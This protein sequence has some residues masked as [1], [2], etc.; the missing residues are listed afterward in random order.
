MLK[1]ERDAIADTKPMPF[2]DAQ[3]VSIGQSDSEYLLGIGA[4]LDD[5]PP[6]ECTQPSP[7]H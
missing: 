4:R 2:E 1:P 7:K 3:L 5:P 6:W